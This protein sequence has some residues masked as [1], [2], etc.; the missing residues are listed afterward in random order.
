M[1]CE[2]GG[3]LMSYDQVHTPGNRTLRKRKCSE[4][5]NFTYTVEYAI[6]YND[7]AKRLWNMNHRKNKME[8][9]KL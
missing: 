9:N 4:C 5:G 7:A 3:K 1:K 6:K 2:C 8:V